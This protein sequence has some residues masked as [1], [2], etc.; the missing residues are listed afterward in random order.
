MDAKKT[1]KKAAEGRE[2]KK[3]RKKKRRRKGNEG[4]GR[5]EDTL[6]RDDGEKKS[7]LG[8]RTTFEK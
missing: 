5:G 6:P 3:Q 7:R 1:E 8:W 2:P 4:R